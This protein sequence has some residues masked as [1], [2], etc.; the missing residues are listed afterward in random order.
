MNDLCDGNE[1]PKDLLSENSKF[2]IDLSH[3]QYS[4]SFD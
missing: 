4:V 3:A 1:K 2:A